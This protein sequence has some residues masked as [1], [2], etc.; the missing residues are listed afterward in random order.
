MNLRGGSLRSPQLNC[1]K[2]PSDRIYKKNVNADI[3]R[4]I[5]RCKAAIE[6][7]RD[8]FWDFGC[9]RGY[10]AKNGP[11]VHEK[12]NHKYRYV[13]LKHYELEQYQHSQRL[14]IDNRH[15]VFV[16]YEYMK[17]IRLFFIWLTKYT[18]L[19]LETR[20]AYNTGKLQHMY[21]VDKSKGIIGRRKITDHVDKNEIVACECYHN[22]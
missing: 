18:K 16:I 9:Q 4:S 5:S 15:K 11:T 1:V 12:E 13:C 6:T 10:Q 19:K 20:A 3:M 8:R 7:Y 14:L 22:V 2:A 21:P 17:Q